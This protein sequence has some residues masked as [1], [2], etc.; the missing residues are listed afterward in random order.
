[1]SS[2]PGSLTHAAARRV[3]LRKRP[4]LIVKVQRYEGRSFFLV[5]DPA[6]LR[7][8]RFQEEEYALLDLLD[9]RRSLDEI[10]ERF[11]AEFRPQKITPEEIQQ[12][13][14]RLH[15]SGLVL[16]DTLGQG[17]RLLERGRKQR[18]RKVTA[19]VTNIL[20]IKLPGFDPERILHWLEPKCRWIFS[21]WGVLGALALMF[22][23]LTLVIVNFDEFQ[24]RPELQSFQAFRSEEHTSEL[25]SH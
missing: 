7:Y 18:K 11:E 25:Q 2:A 17:A 10:K 23:A 1:M 6:G 24:G 4:D 15:E 13:I 16:S 22:S 21:L 20:Y 8:F 5:K 9:G 14:G 19:A 3:A 12:F